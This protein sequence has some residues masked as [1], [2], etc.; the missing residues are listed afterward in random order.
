MLSTETLVEEF[1]PVFAKEK[2][3][4]KETIENY[5]RLLEN[6]QY[7]DSASKIEMKQ[8]CN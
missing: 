8:Q 4:N 1:K 6:V 2:S 5:K 7:D 3:L